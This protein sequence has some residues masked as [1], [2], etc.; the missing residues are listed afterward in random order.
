MMFYFINKVKFINKLNQI[1]VRMDTFKFSIN[2]RKMSTFASSHTVKTIYLKCFYKLFY[3][4]FHCRF[5]FVE[6]IL[7]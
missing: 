4:I 1:M 2:E 3:S 7:S 5:F 6:K